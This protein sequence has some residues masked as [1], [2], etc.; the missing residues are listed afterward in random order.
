MKKIFTLSLE[1]YS[2]S[3]LILNQLKY[4]FNDHCALYLS[5]SCPESR[6]N[7]E[8]IN[9]LMEGFPRDLQ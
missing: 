7:S 4:S 9:L 2:D 5:T 3:I 1:I 8:Q 6:G